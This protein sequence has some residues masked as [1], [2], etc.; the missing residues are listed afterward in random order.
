MVFSVTQVR[1]RSGR[2]WMV[3]RCTARFCAP[4][5]TV[6]LESWLTNLRTK[7]RG[8]KEGKEGGGAGEDV[9]EPCVYLSLI[10]LLSFP[11]LFLS[12]PFPFLSFPF[13]DFFFPSIKSFV[14][15]ASRSPEA[16]KLQAWIQPPLLTLVPHSPISSPKGIFLPQH[17]APGFS[18]SVLM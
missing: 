3:M 13:L 9:C 7:T 8:G 17:V 2:P 18:S 12:F 15:N 1:Q 10:H 14:T 16:E 5:T 4:S 11:F 6:T